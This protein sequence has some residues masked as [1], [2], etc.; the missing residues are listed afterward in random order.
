MNPDSPTPYFSLRGVETSLGGRAVLRGIDLDIPAERTTV[1]LGGS[2]TGKSV[3]LK[4]LNGLIRPDAGSIRINGEEITGRNEGDL[5]PLRRRIGFV[6]QDGALFDSLTVSDN[7][8]FPLREYGETDEEKLRRTLNRLLDQIELR[9]ESEKLPSGLSGGMKKRAAL[10]RALVAE[11]ECLLCDEP[12]AGLDPILSET[13]ARLIRDT[14]RGEKLTSV[15][16]THDL[17]AMEIVA[18]HVVFLHQGEVLFEGTLDELR[19]SDQSRIR[20]FLSARAGGG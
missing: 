19:K 8:L 1:V 10:A 12:T 7:L 14:V 6:F 16:V 15:V 5:A 20:E 17:G 3:L 2:G 18:D 9:G 4:H 11:P 13:V